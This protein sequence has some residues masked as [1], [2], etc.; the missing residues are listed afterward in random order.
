MDTIGKLSRF[1]AKNNINAIKKL[2]EE[3][4]KSISIGTLLK[5]S[6]FE[7]DEVARKQ[8]PRSY[9]KLEKGQTAVPRASRLFQDHEAK[10]EIHKTA[11]L[12]METC[13]RTI[14]NR[15]KPINMIHDDL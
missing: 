14:D 13:F 15:A 8:L 9:L 2:H 4:K 3:C 12:T 6:N 1:I 7:V 10:S 5:L 11:V